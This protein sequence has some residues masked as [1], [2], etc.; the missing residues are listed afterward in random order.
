MNTFIQKIA[1]ALR[2]ASEGAEIFI[3]QVNDDGTVR[4]DRVPINQGHSTHFNR[5]MYSDFR[6][7]YRT[8]SDRVLWW[9][10]KDVTDEMQHEVE[11]YL[12]QEGYHVHRHGAMT[13]N[14]MVDGKLIDGRIYGHGG[15]RSARIRSRVRIA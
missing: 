13:A 6:W 7:R 15:G 8:D 5:G 11:Q 2:L 4:A 14:L 3:G 1:A 12:A 10:F 9:N